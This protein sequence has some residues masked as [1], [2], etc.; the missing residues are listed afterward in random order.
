MAWFL[1]KYVCEECG[2]AWEDE[3]SCGC[4]DDCAHCGARHM[5]PIDSVDLSEVIREDDDLFL[6]LKSLDSAE[7]TPE[8]R[9]LV[10]FWTREEAERFLKAR[11]T[12]PN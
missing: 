10:D 3:W 11:N 1:N 7:R 6:V 9:I 12:P 8:Y 2:Y 4:D 5:E